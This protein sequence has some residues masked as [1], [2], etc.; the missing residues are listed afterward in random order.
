MQSSIFLKKMNVYAVLFTRKQC[1]IWRLGPPPLT[2]STIFIFKPN[3][4]RHCYNC[5]KPGV[6][7]N[8]WILKIFGDFENWLGTLIPNNLADAVLLS[9]ILKVLGEAFRVWWALDNGS[10]A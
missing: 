10:V 1:W 7:L 2:I 4:G 9:F 6:L 8:I 3:T 5:P